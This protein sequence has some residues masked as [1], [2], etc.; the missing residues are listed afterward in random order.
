[1]RTFIHVKPTNKSA[2][3]AHHARYISERERDLEREEPQSRPIFTHDRDGLKH[4]AADRYLAGGEQSKAKTNELHH[5]IIAFNAADAKEL[6]KL[7]GRKK[8][9]K[10]IDAEKVSIGGDAQ[11]VSTPDDA[12]K[13]SRAENSHAQIDRDLPYA[14]AV[15]RMMDNLEERTDLSELRY[16][17][18]VHRHTGHTHVHLLLR[19]EYTDKE[20]GEKAKLEHR[21]PVEFLNG[22]DER[23]KA[24]GGL[25]DVALSDALD[26][27]IP[28]RQRTPR[29]ATDARQ[30]HAEHEQIR[31]AGFLS[32]EDESQDSI[33]YRA[34]KV[35]IEG[36]IQEDSEEL[37]ARRRIRFVAHEA[38]NN[39]THTSPAPGFNHPAPFLRAVQNSP[40]LTTG[41]G[42]QPGQSALKERPHNGF[43]R[44]DGTQP[45]PFYAGKVSTGAY[46][47]AGKVSITEPSDSPK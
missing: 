36:N 4:T 17:L 42:E 21:F 10:E 16:A 22:R 7:E 31:D 2:K 30:V 34:Q 3:T 23:N 9:V 40:A 6:K 39:N 12:E 47:Y 15:R 26:T 28:R 44:Q 14:Q 32:I 35:S 24:R 25:F 18:A 38:I 43:T 33:P 27:M 1:M 5:I 20:T 41:A 45:D 19:R 29:Q 46:T 8:E 13:L 37:E 11:K